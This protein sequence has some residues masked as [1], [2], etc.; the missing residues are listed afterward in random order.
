LER[1]WGGDEELLADRDA[2]MSAI[3]PPDSAQFTAERADSVLSDSDV[4]PPGAEPAISIRPKPL[5][6]PSFVLPFVLGLIGLIGGCLVAWLLLF[7]L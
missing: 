3:P 2:V 6:Q 5:H 4:P 1:A 7:G